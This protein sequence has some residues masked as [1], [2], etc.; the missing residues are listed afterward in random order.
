MSYTEYFG[1][2]KEPFV[3]EIL[4]KDLLHLPGTLSVKQRMD[5]VLKNGGVMVVTGDVGVGKST[6][7]RWS[8]D[9]YHKSEVHCVYITATSGSSIELYK[10]MGWGLKIEMKTGS[11]VLLLK[12]LKAAIEEFVNQRQGKLVVVIDEASLIRSEVF[13]ELH[14][15]TQFNYD[16]ASLF[17]LILVGQNSLLDKLSY[18]TSAPL[19]SRVI[20]RTHLG[21]LERDQMCDYLKHHLKVAGIK[22]NLFSET[23]ITAIHQGSGGLLRKANSLARGSLI[24]C[25]I[26]KVNMV[27]DEHV[28]KAS[29]ELI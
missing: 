20:T 29:T 8:L 6:S 18:R 16:S 28:R 15:L 27:N 3:N 12:N 14:T 7:L 10:Q 1:M 24:G 26:D 17:S 2:K 9:Q 22:A 23:A 4:T 13:S 5:Y 19:A 25:M 21:S 11:K